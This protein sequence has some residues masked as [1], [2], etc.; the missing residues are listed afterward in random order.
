M[1]VKDNKKTI[2]SVILI[3]LV[4]IFICIFFKIIK[5]EEQNKEK[6][7]AQNIATVEELKEETGLTGNTEIYEVQQEFDGRQ[8]LTVKANIKYKVAFAGM[9][10]KSVPTMEE[11]DTILNENLP[12]ENGIWIEKDSRDKILN[13]FNNENVNSKYT[14]DNNGY[15]RI[16]EK[17]KQNDIDKKIDKIINGD[18]QY[19]L[20]VSSVCYIVDELSGDI[21]N[22]TFE[23]MDK[24]QTY[25]YF[26]DDNKMIVFINENSK[27]Q[28]TNEEI[29]NSIV[30][31]F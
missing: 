23:K 25:E 13:L 17:N 26:Q 11:L 20:D 19:I 1:V 22:Y 4:I 10:K 31:L 30:E 18:K 28:L 16:Q 3:I 9:I 12:K 7:S 24:F 27:N 2:I 29:F 8:V 6:D 15:L 14:I 5:K 21:W